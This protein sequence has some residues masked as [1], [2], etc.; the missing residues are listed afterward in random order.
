MSLFGRGGGV[1]YVLPETRTLDATFA[2]I[3]ATASP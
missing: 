3:G 2:F 1:L